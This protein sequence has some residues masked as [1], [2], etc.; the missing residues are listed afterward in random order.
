MIRI[1]GFGT[2]VTR[3]MV[4]VFIACALVPVGAALFAG[5]DRVHEALVA[6]RLMLLRDAAAGYGGAL[7]D[8]LN[9]ADAIAHS[10]ALG[11]RGEASG[12]FRAGVVLEP[13]GG[14]TLLFG[15]TD[16]MPGR[17]ELA[18]LDRRLASG[19]SGLAM[20]RLG[21]GSVAL[22]LVRDRPPRRVALELD[23]KYLWAVEDL[24]YLTDL[25]VVGPDGAPMTCT[26]PL[27]E[28]A[29]AALRGRSTTQPHGDIAWSAEGTR[30]LSGFHEVFLRGRF[31][32][33][34]WTIVAS[35]PEWHAL[36]PVKAVGQLVIPV[37]LL[38]LLG[39][40]LVGVVLVRRMLAP[41]QPLTA[42]ARRLGAGDFSAR[43][44]GTRDDEFGALGDAFNAMSSR[45]GRQFN[46]LVAHA[47]IDAEILSGVDLPRIVAI[48]LRRMAELAPADRHYLVLADPVGA[49]YTLYST[50]GAAPLA[51]SEGEMLRLLAAP[52][53]AAALPGI[54]GARVSAL[55]IALERRYA[56]AMVLA[57][58]QVREP[59]ADELPLLRD[60]ADR[61]AVALTAARRE[62]E[63]ERRANYD[64]LTQ[65]PNRAL[66]LE[67]LTRAVSAA[68]RSG[69]AL[70]V[71][72]VD[73][74][75]FAD[76]NDSAGHAVGDQVLVQAAL[77]LRRCLRKSDLV[78][79]LGGDEFAVVLPEVRDAVDAA[80]AARHV[81][82][83]LST[84]FQ[85]G[86]R[87]FVT[88]GV[89]IALYP[90]D[91]AGAEELLRHADLAMLHAKSGGRGQVAFFAPAMN[92]EIR[93]RVELEREL[94]HA[95]DDNQFVLHYQ[96]QLDLKLGRIV[97][98]EA[99]VRWMHPQRGLV[100]PAQFIAFAESSGLI[101][102]IGRWA[103]R[104]A[105]AQFV[106][107]RAQGLDLGYVAVNVSPR[108][109]RNPG[110][111]EM[112][113]GALREYLMP[114]AALH[115][116]ITE[117]AVMNNDAARANLAGLSALGTP[118]ELDDFG[119]GYSSLAH[120][121]KLPIVAIKIDRAFVR[122]IEAER[123][124]QAVVRAAIEMAHALGKTV[125]GEGVE[126]AGQLELLRSMGCDLV[127][128]YVLSAP[129]T[130]A[131]FADLLRSRPAAA[132]AEG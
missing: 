128:G 24:P 69:R 59:T 7:V 75:G 111:T 89:G 72:F 91:G 37:L 32:A 14:R 98:A 36:A 81:I 112:V 83:A 58:D 10:G 15:D 19:A 62:R 31:G 39:A 99:L 106:T 25:C 38:A 115:L 68:E 117:S 110:F 132:R 47:E 90:G 94:H 12:Y 102:D 84:P 67:E 97:G 120:L 79:R 109:F 93:R 21:D 35:Q 55:P 46:S 123:S 54:A 30:Y 124:A 126:H 52:E 70:A 26:R 103:L 82:E 95:L 50:A 40:A 87:V 27:P 17:R 130:A 1:G 48:V 9:A 53:G 20:V 96:P 34:T 16:R 60:L 116:E 113:A 51:L 80:Q 66:G 121:Q 56:G 3:R 76:V 18:D 4:A 33:G 78:A 100:P 86:A 23:P 29:L 73:L 77:R 43:V 28:A 118:L 5:Y 2:R 85:V 107:W 13:G 41:L 44:S 8:R 42:A 49:G 122:D 64:P 6:Q 61:V 22:W 131:K 92:A 88:A 11:A 119:T 105:V 74:D 104:A 127:Q 129:V 57:Y 63:L 114:A 125:V 45:L 65:L 71:L 108:Q 101:E